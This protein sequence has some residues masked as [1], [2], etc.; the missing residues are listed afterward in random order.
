[1]KIHSISVTK[2]KLDKIPEIERAFYVH[3]GHLRNELMVPR[4]LLERSVKNPPDNPVLGDV[5]F[6]QSFIIARLLA[7]KLWEGW[8]LMRKAYFST[9]LS[10]MIE[11]K[12][13]EDTKD[14]LGNLKKYFGKKNVIDSVRNEFA[15]H[16]N[17]QRVRTQLFLVEETDNLK[18]YAAETEDVLF[19]FSEIIVG[20][21]M[22]GAVQTGDSS[23]LAS[24]AASLA[25]TPAV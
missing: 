19:Q 4:K 18:I 22:L 16:Y 15:F 6:S 1:M 21:A 14:A 10:L 17:A 3:I 8:E 12:L 20:S 13:P 24:S 9:K 11:S 25:S 5:N 2:A 7:G 23:S